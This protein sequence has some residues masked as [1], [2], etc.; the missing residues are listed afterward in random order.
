VCIARVFNLTFPQCSTKTKLACRQLF[1]LLLHQTIK[2]RPQDT[3]LQYWLEVKESLKKSTKCFTARLLHSCFSL[4]WPVPEWSVLTINLPISEYFQQINCNKI[5]YKINNKRI[6]QYEKDC[7][8]IK[9]IRF[10]KSQL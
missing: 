2:S 1:I 6:D 3:I 5:N 9:L 7:L 8:S 4:F 10:S